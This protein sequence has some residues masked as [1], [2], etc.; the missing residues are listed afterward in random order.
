MAP[1]LRPPSWCRGAGK[2]SDSC[3]VGDG[4]LGDTEML[5]GWHSMRPSL[6][7]LT[8]ACSTLFAYRGSPPELMAM[9]GWKVLRTSG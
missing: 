3:V 7:S 8:A 5:A 4:G 9:A 1:S 2:T 6:V